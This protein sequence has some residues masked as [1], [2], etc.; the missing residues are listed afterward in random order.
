MFLKYAWGQCRATEITGRAPVPAK[1][2]AGAHDGTVPRT[3]SS[4]GHTGQPSPGRT[5]RPPATSRAQ[6]LAA[7]RELLRRDGWEKVTG[8]PAA[9]RPGSPRA[10][11]G[12]L[13]CADPGRGA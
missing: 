5:G 2:A 3:S 10:A 1:P 11:A 4:P 9:G 12:R 13:P 6:I 8:R 7:A